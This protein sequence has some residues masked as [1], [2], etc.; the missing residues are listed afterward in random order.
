M[1][2]ESAIAL[3][4]V[5]VMIWWEIIGAIL[6]ILRMRHDAHSM[7]ADEV[8]DLIDKIDGLREALD[9]EV[10]N[11]LAE[12]A[13]KYGIDWDGTENFAEM[14]TEYQCQTFEEQEANNAKSN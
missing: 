7:S 6:L 9:E 3:A 11:N 13:A 12:V 1:D 10:A 8:I 5:I 4:I 14:P 2:T